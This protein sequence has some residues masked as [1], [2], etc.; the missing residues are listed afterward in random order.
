MYTK[1]QKRM[2]LVREVVFWLL[3]L[4]IIVP[5]LIVVFNAFKTKPEALNMELSLPTALHLR[6]LQRFGKTRIS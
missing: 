5:F 6:T 2:L 4:I 1:K 3:S